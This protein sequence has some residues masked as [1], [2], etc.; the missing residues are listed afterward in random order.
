MLPTKIRRN[1]DGE[2]AIC[3]VYHQVIWT[4]G[5]HPDH[6]AIRRDRFIGSK[7]GSRG[8]ATQCLQLA[9]RSRDEAA[10]ASFCC[11]PPPAA[12]AS[13]EYL[14]ARTEFWGELV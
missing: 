6:S 13:N 10:P 3:R 4:P 7:A 8:H 11:S 12:E 1:L 5:H 14:P 9:Q 2:C